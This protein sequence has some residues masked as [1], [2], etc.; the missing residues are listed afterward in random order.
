MA[1]ETKR[2][3]LTA[4]VVRSLAQEAGATEQQIREMV[5]L[6][7]FDR[8]SIL[9]EARVV[10]RKRP[11]RLTSSA[12]TTVGFIPKLRADWW[13]THGRVYGPRSAARSMGAVDREMPVLLP[14]RES[15]V[16]IK[17]LQTKSELL[18]RMSADDFAR[19]EPY[20]ENVFLEL[21][22]PLENAG[23]RIESVYFLESGIASIVARTSPA[24][25]AEVGMIGFE[26]MTG[27]ALIMGDEQAILDC[28][29]QSTS[30]A[31]R[32]PV[33]P[34]VKA[35]EDSPTLRPF[36]LRYVQYLHVQTSYTASINARQGLEVR[37]ARWL[38]MCSDRTVG[39]HLLITH[40]FLAVMLGVRRPGVTV[41]L[42][43]IESH[44]YIRARRGEITI[45]NRDGLLKL[46]RE[47]YGP[48]EI[49]YRRLV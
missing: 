22:S 28:Y 21:R 47:A 18:R 35:L 16:D 39:D 13:R 38:L 33:A 10:A 20:L 45:R 37:L 44:G 31:I 14:L 27:S 11:A 1:N 2:P 48:P 15:L 9:R 3:A 6:I 46:A 19:L 40:E 4:E 8:S 26:G 41:G 23:Q 42:Q 29:I 49:E 7:G 17:I 5:S 30:E 43:M 25:E 12:A 36:L 34:F 32:M 24:T